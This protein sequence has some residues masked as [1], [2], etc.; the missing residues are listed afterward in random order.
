[1]K[2]R[3]FILVCFLF[4]AAFV[5]AQKT[6]TPTFKTVHVRPGVVR[7][8]GYKL[9]AVTTTRVSQKVLESEEFRAVTQFA[10]TE[11]NFVGTVEIGTTSKM[12]IELTPQSFTNNEKA[13]LYL[14]FPLG[15]DEYGFSI[16]DLPGYTVKDLNLKQSVS[17]D[18]DVTAGKKYS[19]MIPI[20]MANGKTRTITIYYGAFYSNS[21]MFSIS[22][23]GTQ[24]VYFTVTAETTGRMYFT[25]KE[26]SAYQ[27]GFWSF[28]KV[29]I[30][31]L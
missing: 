18:F 13:I 26:T 1:M 20:T 16:G 17:I 30:A 9:P 12:K 10:L 22:F 19:V 25:L 21:T 29:I 27:T 31:E 14:H 28:P 6:T 7:V 4:T 2:N 15:I 5:S 23:S 11:A 24:E 3:L 8:P